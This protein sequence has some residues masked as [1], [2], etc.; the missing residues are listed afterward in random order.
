MTSDML[1]NFLKYEK[2]NLVRIT[3]NEE[4][5]LM[6]V[7]YNLNSDTFEG[8][9][10]APQGLSWSLPYMLDARGIVLDSVTGE[11]VARPY[12]KF[13]NYGENALAQW[14][15]DYD[16]MTVT[17]KLDGSLV[18]Y[19]NYQNRNI[20]AS[21]GS[22]ISEHAVYFRNWFEQ[23][24]SK[25][26]L[27]K[28]FSFGKTYTLLFEHIG[29]NAKIAIDYPEEKMVLHG[30]IETATGKS[31]SYMKVQ[32]TAQQLGL[33]AIHEEPITKL[34]DLKK[35]MAGHNDAYTEG[36]VVTFQKRGVTTRLKF[37]TELYIELHYMLSRAQ[38]LFS[39]LSM[40]TF[41]KRGREI[42]LDA[43]YNNEIDD[44]IALNDRAKPAILK[45]ITTIRELTQAFNT[46][47]QE[48][49][50]PILE[51]RAV[52][53]KTHKNA[54]AMAYIWASGGNAEDMVRKYV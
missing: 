5:Q 12:P 6:S 40:T 26:E 18:I 35:W 23:H 43:Y 16:T 8:Y 22:T 34:S 32:K 49:G 41:S 27:E 15:T 33:E 31:I 20:F 30:M 53:F 14:V 21:S 45:L 52:Y 1:E 38:G 24:L 2:E 17:D 39:D 19:S 48:H 9:D 29:P 50:E 4:K 3:R 47:V 11:I 54:P 7:K 36:L 46:F 28:L 44:L 25:D 10:E 13:F 51:V 42:V 37:K